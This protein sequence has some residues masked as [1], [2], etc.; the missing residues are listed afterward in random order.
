MRKVTLTILGAMLCALT[1]AQTYQADTSSYNVDTLL[2]NGDADKF[3]NLVILSDGYME[4][5]LSQFELDAT[6]VMN[7]L[8]SVEPYTTYQSYF[9]VFIIKVPSNESGAN[10]PGTLSCTAE[11]PILEVDN[12]FESTFDIGYLHR[13]LA[14]PTPWKVTDV[15]AYNFP[16]YDEAVVLVNTPYYGGSGGTFATLSTHELSGDL[17][18]HELAHSFVDLKDEYWP[19]EVYAG[20]AANM[21]Q[22]SDPE[23]V[24]WKNWVSE[25]W[26]GVFE[27]FS[28]AG[29]YRP[30]NQCRMKILSPLL[31]GVPASFC[32]VCREATVEKIHSLC[33][34][35]QEYQPS[36]SDI[37]SPSFPLEFQVEL[38]Q[39]LSQ[40]LHS[41]WS[42]NG[43]AIESNTASIS[44]QQADL[45]QGVNILTFD[46]QD[47]T[48]MLRIDNHEEIHAYEISW[49][50]E[51]GETEILC[52]NLNFPAGWSIFSTYISAENMAADYLLNPL[53]NDNNLVIVKNHMGTA[54]LPSYDVNGIGAIENEQ[55]YLAKNNFTQTIEICGESVLPEETPISLNQ[56]WGMFSYLRYEAADL[57]AVFSELQDEIIIIKNSVGDAFLPDWGFNGI[58]D[59]EPGKGYQIKMSSPQIL[60]Y[61]ANDQEY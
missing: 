53:N 42:L 1:S 40:A 27:Y 43:V 4:A 35:V 57:S 17:F 13:L 15:L 6:H 2:Y 41:N 60:I 36:S 23:I 48:D 21:T 31:P 45:N 7:S 52:Q 11:H 25:D 38:I 9:N 56:G 44:I 39:P 8:F 50:I 54:Y 5:E 18:I 22:E 47:A 29:W 30:H 14:S 19:G 37:Y 59:L 12:Y 33:T 49:T 55:G 58:G 10:H 34:P 3:I 51:N 32:K 61:L 26:H 20:E 16:M 28:G 46:V 24:R